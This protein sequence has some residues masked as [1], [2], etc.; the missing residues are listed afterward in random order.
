MLSMLFQGSGV[1]EGGGI[2]DMQI[3]ETSDWG[4][5]LAQNTQR[6]VFSDFFVIG[7][8]DTV[9]RQMRVY[10]VAH[11][12]HRYLFGDRVGESRGSGNPFLGKSERFRSLT[13]RFSGNR[14]LMGHN[15]ASVCLIDL[16]QLLTGSS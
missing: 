7:G 8:S 11:Y 10:G 13:Y 4:P 2:D 14:S 6:S 5:I 9:Y 3:L 12:D 1:V 15:F 16:L